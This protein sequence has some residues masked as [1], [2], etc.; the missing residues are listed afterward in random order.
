LLL[1][2]QGAVWDTDFGL[3]KTL[4]QDGLTRPGE[5]AGTLRYSAP[6]RF[7]GRSDA[8]SDIYSLGLTLYELLTLR[9]AYDETDPGRL[10]SQVMNGGAP[11]PRSHTPAIP[12]DL[13]PIVLK[14]VAPEPPRRYQSACELADDLRRFLDDRPVRARR[15]SPVEHAWRWCRRNPAVA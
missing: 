5:M 8:R 7:Q 11:R 12:R 3:A 9:P 14:A 15:G 10:L 4:E 1:D 6:E 13:E 2:E